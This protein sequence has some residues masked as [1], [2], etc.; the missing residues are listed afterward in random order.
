MALLL[1]GCEADCLVPQ[2]KQIHVS[3]TYHRSS[4]RFLPRE[5]FSPLAA[6]RPSTRGRKSTFSASSRYPK[7]VSPGALSGWLRHPG[8][9]T[10]LQEGSVNLRTDVISVLDHQ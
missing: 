8:S 1:S 7:T 9:S 6:K 4:R 5:R 3:A 10:R 2:H